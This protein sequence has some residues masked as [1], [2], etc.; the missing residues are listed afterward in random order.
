M[1]SAL[2]R[3]HFPELPELELQEKI[4]EF[5]TRIDFNPG[6]TIMDYGQY[7]RFVPMV[8]EGSIKIMREDEQGNELILYYL[9]P[10]ETCAVSLTCCMA[11]K[12]SSIRAV[13][14]DDVSII[15]IPI[16][17]MDEWTKDHPSWKNFVMNTYQHRFEE[18]LH[19][20]DQIAFKRM[21]ERLIKYLQDKTDVLDSMTIHISHQEI[22][23]EL[24]TSREVVSRL[25]KKLERMGALKLGRNK[26]E[27]LE[28]D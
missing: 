9:H 16:K 5:G 8:L 11:N 12:K 21:D 14:E 26:I 2:I 22:A 4:A 19:T 20:L 13:A 23:K 28:L 10:G 3:T 18:M 25:L 17:Y 7:I 6:E 27:I 24:N 15:A 1:D